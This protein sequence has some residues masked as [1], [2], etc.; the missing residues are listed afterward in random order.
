MNHFV[1][2]LSILINSYYVSHLNVLQCC[3][4][5]QLHRWGQL[6]GRVP[7]WW[8]RGHRF[9]PQQDNFCLQSALLTVTVNPR[10]DYVT[11]VACET[12]TVK[13]LCHFASHAGGRL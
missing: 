2:Y 1:N 5:G 9:N 12:K 8:P 11:A 4:W 10:Y 3:R 13:D 6:S 7:G